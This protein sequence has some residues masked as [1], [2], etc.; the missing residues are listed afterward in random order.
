MEKKETK[1]NKM[2]QKNVGPVTQAK[3]R[4]FLE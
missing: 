1:Q 4:G 3:E 2:K